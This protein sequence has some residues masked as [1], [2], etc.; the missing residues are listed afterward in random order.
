M[1]ASEAMV[2]TDRDV[3][4]NLNPA[5][6]LEWGV[7]RLEEAEIESAVI[8][9]RLLLEHALGVTREALLQNEVAI[10]DSHV[11]LYDALI[12]R[13]LQFEPVSRIIGHRDFWKHRFTVTPA[14]LD[15]RPDSETVIEAVLKYVPQTDAPIGILDLGTGTGCLLLSLL[16]EYPQALGVG[17]D[18]SEDALKVARGNALRLE[19]AERAMFERS[20]WCS[21]VRGTFDVIVANPP[22]VAEKDRFNLMPDVR[23][24]D[25]PAALFGGADGLDAYRAILPA[26][27]AHM[28]PSSLAF[29]EIGAGQEADVESLAASYGYRFVALSHD[30]AGIGRVVVLAYDNTNDVNREKEE[31]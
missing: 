17:V 24:Y 23:D 3:P 9:A 28:T 30:L 12:A 16:G 7:R 29:F 2:W 14:T 27:R 4:D 6:L 18:Q 1:V 11:V 13:R 20:D 8:D 15:P 10:S 21:N 5:Q 19:M 31:S 25:P 26:L 22:Y